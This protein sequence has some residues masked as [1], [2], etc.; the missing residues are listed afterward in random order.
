MGTYVGE[1][2]GGLWCASFPVLQC[3]YIL[4]IRVKHRIEDGHCCYK[5]LK[6]SVPAQLR[7]VVMGCL[8]VAVIGDQ[9]SAGIQGD[10]PAQGKIA[11]V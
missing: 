2:R 8:V 7:S 6:V 4:G 11:V 5:D 9:A 10:S 1:M 3:H